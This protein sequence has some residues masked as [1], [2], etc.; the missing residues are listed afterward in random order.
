MLHML[1]LLQP[2]MQHRMQ[3][4]RSSTQLRMLRTARSMQLMQRQVRCSM[5]HM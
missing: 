2:R 3:G 1:L 5:E 4:T